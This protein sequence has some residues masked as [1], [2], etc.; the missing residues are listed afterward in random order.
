MNLPEPSSV[1]RVA[2]LG[3]GL[4]GASWTAFFLSRGLTC[5]V[6]DPDSA[7]EPKVRSVI[8][9]AWPI[10]TELGMATGADPAA[11][12]LT[13]DPADAV[14]G[15]QFVQEQA[16]ERLEIKRDLFARIDGPLGPD[17]VVA[18]STSGLLV[19]DMQDGLEH[20]GRYVVGH[21]F[22]PPHLIPLVE[23]VGGRLT[24]PA[25]VDWSVAFYRHLGKV[26]VRLNKEVHGHIAN[27]LQAAIWREA[28]HLV[29][30]GVA[31]VA[32]VDAAVAYG[33]GLRWA[34]MGPH[35]TYHLGGGQGG[36]EWF[37]EHLGPSA[38]GR[39]KDLGT[40]QTIPDGA[41]PV[42]VE[43]VKAEAGGASIDAL[44]RDRDRLLLGLLKLIGTGKGTLP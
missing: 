16:P 12:R 4:I 1:R 33:P 15:A 3:G 7:A 37:I 8:E 2:V 42:L 27:R 19:S 17:A 41:K 32:A 23:V 29:A 5:T 31:D 21:P 36:L 18:T 26:A 30:E 20:A 13:T 40:L 6:Y 10:L 11:W 9:A 24:D 43:G 34:L 22:N 35:L 39:W 25:A 28:V 44:A 38:E 14:R